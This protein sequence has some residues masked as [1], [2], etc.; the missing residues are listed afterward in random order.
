MNTCGHDAARVT[1]P[2]RCTKCGAYAHRVGEGFK[3][4][5]R[6]RWLTEWLFRRWARR[7]QPPVLEGRI[8]HGGAG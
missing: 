4:A 8:T 5:P 6:E 1:P 2:P 3:V 7:N